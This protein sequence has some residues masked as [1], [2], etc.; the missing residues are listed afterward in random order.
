MTDT[1]FSD[2]TPYYTIRAGSPK[3][4]LV[5]DIDDGYDFLIVWDLG[6]RLA[7]LRGET[8]HR[9]ALTDIECS[10]RLVI[11]TSLHISRSTDHLK[12]RLPIDAVN[13]WDKTIV[14]RHTF[15]RMIEEFRKDPY[16]M[17]TRMVL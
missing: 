14:D 5:Y 16:P 1:V 3:P 10:I 13:D 7:A 6:D 4:C 8:Y 11:A 15:D 17:L 9:F 12:I 2:L